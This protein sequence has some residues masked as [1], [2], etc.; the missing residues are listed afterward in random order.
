MCVD[1]TDLKKACPKDPL[2][3]PRIDQVVNSTAGC[4]LL[5]FLDAYSGYH[6]IALKEDDYLKASFITLLTKNPRSA[7]GPHD[8]GWAECPRPM[9]RICNI[10]KTY[11]I[12][13]SIL[14]F[15]NRW[16]ALGL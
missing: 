6:Q 4:E 1:Y 14:S 10:R 9:P 13:K 11:R 12:R 7:F 5:S 15:V 8:M 2:G 16:Q 3:L